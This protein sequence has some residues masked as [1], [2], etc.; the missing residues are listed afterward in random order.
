MSATREKLGSFEE[1]KD[2]SSID[3]HILAMAGFY[4]LSYV[5]RLAI[6]V[7]DSRNRVQLIIVL[8]TLSIHWTKARRR[9]VSS[10]TSMRVSILSNSSLATV[11]TETQESRCC[12][13]AFRDAR[14]ISISHRD[15]DALQ[16]SYATYF[17]YFKHDRNNLQRSSPK[18]GIFSIFFFKRL[19]P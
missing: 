4:T 18:S 2:W 8:V 11:Q 14:D 3:A 19:I 13:V 15:V 10:T 1:L 12:F 16:C 9:R 5:H 7:F 17:P 6:I